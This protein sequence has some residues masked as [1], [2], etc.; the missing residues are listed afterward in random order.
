[1]KLEGANR[2]VTLMVDTGSQIS[3]I[4]ADALKPETKYEEKERL[5]LIGLYGASQDTLGKLTG[6]LDMGNGSVSAN[7]QVIDNRNSLYVDGI[8]GMDFLWRYGSIINVEEE[9]FDINLARFDPF[10]EAIF[11]KAAE[12]RKENNKTKQVTKKEI[13][14]VKKVSTRETKHNFPPS[15][16][17]FDEIEVISSEDLPENYFSVPIQ[18]KPGPTGTTESTADLL[19]KQQIEETKP[20]PSGTAEPTDA[21]VYK[22]SIEEAKPGPPGTTWSTD[23]LLYK[24]YIEEPES[25]EQIIY[26]SEEGAKKCLKVH[27]DEQS[28]AESLIKELQ[29][30][31]YG[32]EESQF[33]ESL[34][35]RYNDVFYM[36]GDKLTYTEVI[37]HR[38]E[39]KPDTKPIYV[40]QYRLPEIQ[41]EEIK[42]Q[43]QEMEEN[44]IIEPCH[45]QWNA[46]IMLVKKKEDEN[47]NKE[48]RLVV[49]FKKL[50]EATIPRNFPIPL[51][52]EILDDLKG[53]QY[54]TTLDLHGAFHQILLHPDDRD[55]T[56]FSTG[57]F[58]YRWVRMPMGLTSS[59]H[60]WQC[61][62]NSI[63]SDMLG[64]SIHIYLDD[65]LLTSKTFEEH[66]QLIKEVFQRLREFRLKLKIKKTAFFKKEVE[67]LGHIISRHG[68][69]PSMKKVECIKNY[70]TP[71]NVT[72][73]QRFTGMSGYFRKYIQDYAKLAGPMYEL[74]KK[75][76]PY[77][78]SDRCDKG[79]KGLKEA[80][81]SPQVLIFPNFNET[82]IVT[83]DASDFAIGAVLSQGEVPHDRPI[84]YFSKTLNSAQRNYSTIEKEL[85]AIVTAVEQY[86]HF[87]YGREFIVI[88][89]HK[90]LC[91]MISHKNPS[92]RLYRWKLALMEYNFK[93]IH[94]SGAKNY[95]ADAL[96]RIE[97]PSNTALSLDEIV[98]LNGE[99][100][101]INIITRSMRQPTDDQQ[102]NTVINNPPIRETYPITEN[103]H[104][105]T[106]SNEF[107]YILFLLPGRQCQLRTRIEQKMR[108]TLKIPVDLEENTHYPLDNTRAVIV[109]DPKTRKTE[110]TYTKIIETILKY[111]LD[112]NKTN[113]AINI[114]FNDH[115]SYFTFK[116]IY[117][118]VFHGS[119][120]ATT[121]YLNN[122]VTVTKVKDIDDIL[123]MY[124]KSLLGGHVGVERMKNN[125][126]RY[127][128]WP[129]LTKDIKEFIKS[130]AT[131]E[132]TKITTHTRSP[133]QIT[134][135]GI[136]PF[137]HVYIDFVGPITPPSAEGHHYLFTMTC[138]LTKY[139][140]AVPTVDC[141][142][143]TTA[144]AFVENLIL[145]FNIPT[146]VT[147]DNATNFTA[148]T[149]KEIS[150]LLKIKN[151]PTSPYHP[152]SNI[153]ERWHRTL[154]TYMKAYIEKE[155]DTWHTTISYALF[156][157][158]NCVHTS[159]GYTPNELVFGHNIKLPT[160]I[161]SK[162]VYNYENYRDE[163]RER[164]AG[165]QKF[166]KESIMKQK[167]AN[168]QQYDKKTKPLNLNKNDLVLMKKTQRK[169]KF[170][171]PY[172]GPYRVEEVTTDVNAKI[173][174]GKK[175]V[176]V[177]ND[178]LKLAQ[179]NHGPDT[180]PE[181]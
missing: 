59:P 76:T 62:I 45:S 124:H 166:A 116:T 19:P 6:K 175:L 147:T 161:K 170:E 77:I 14:K 165:T 118:K 163:L 158:N 58:K 95:V 28:R 107:D 37:Q 20:G 148:E 181:V 171:Q 159:T 85:L 4:K 60:T 23:A 42:K 109:L 145:K 104:V 177:H 24:Q 38:I 13:P 178:Q 113:L 88:T 30:N 121:F 111:T 169:Q 90:P 97:V 143:I 122:V 155:P 162:P 29:K 69:R 34:C 114:D 135:V 106:S 133:M 139:A 21:L 179:A 22:Q 41:K 56:A 167:N 149:T 129:S 180:P 10:R 75:D 52:D 67:Y 115:T 123:K 43:L 98:E 65:L 105:Q 134:S 73:I 39:L 78:W 8:L 154:G 27:I 49:D 9:W 18:Q 94:R 146:K 63:F 84:Q 11:Q 80:L 35:R 150:K 160:T 172:E 53:A 176:R 46:P 61:A 87:L 81:I 126:R 25:S 17:N 140:I 108:T 64:K 151:I 51:I 157:Y 93:V 136:A 174:K 68:S 1:M 31:E 44:G 125:I 112:N 2:I 110:E 99:I 15:A 66:K 120:T 156:A 92:S 130:C 142:A 152:N 7:F 32:K 79:F 173:R 57:H 47:G 3:L 82:F 127:Y 74:L 36:D 48:W 137:D 101:R 83:T 164:L 5:R 16:T 72:E 26:E 103:N 153:V 50:N 131:C 102:Q 119:T 89:D 100:K 138:D 54:F 33:L 144:K 117:R 86:R 168:K 132:K 71:K 91:F 55:Y 96:S 40:R 128:T 70:P 12:L 141:S